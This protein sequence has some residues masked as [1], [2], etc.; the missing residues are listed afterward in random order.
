M[1]L[2][3]KS[4]WLFFTDFEAFQ[5]D[6]IVSTPPESKVA[7]EVNEDPGKLNDK[8]G[9]TDQVPE[10]EALLDNPDNFNEDLEEIEEKEPCT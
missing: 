5:L 10:T 6:E 9:T 4:T 2:D 1:N 7:S 8:D 3:F